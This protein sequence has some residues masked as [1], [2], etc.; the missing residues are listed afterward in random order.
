M[1]VKEL[2]HRLQDVNQDFDVKIAT[3]ELSSD[4]HDV[5]EF[6]RLEKVYIL[7]E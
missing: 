2:I 4:V 7:G 5:K 6:K 3:Q 1:T